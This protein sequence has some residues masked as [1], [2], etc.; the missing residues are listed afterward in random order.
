MKKCM[1]VTLVMAFLFAMGSSCCM[2]QG[3]T[4]TSK[5]GSLLIFPK[6]DTRAGTTTIVSLLNAGSRSIDVKC[7]WEYKSSAE[8]T[9]AGNISDCYYS[10]MQFRLT[11]NHPLVFDAATGLSGNEDYQ[12]PGSNKTPQVAGFGEGNLGM[13]KC[14]AVDASAQNQVNWNYLKGEATILEEATDLGLFS[15]WEYNA[16]RF[17][18]VMPAGALDKD[19]V[20]TGGELR[21]TGSANGTGAYDAC[22]TYIGFEFLAEVPAGNTNDITLI[23]CKQNVK[24]EGSFTTTKATFTVWNENEVKFTGTHK[25]FRCF[26]EDSLYIIGIPQDNVR[27]RTFTAAVLQTDIGRARVKGLAS[28]KYCP[29]LNSVN[30]PLLGVIAS[31]FDT[32]PDWFGTNPTTAGKAT[33]DPGYIF[34]DAGEDTPEKPAL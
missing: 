7:Y 10:D 4:D 34:W 22:P 30:S 26:M 27:F 19:P 28:A 33:A 9:P 16:W 23:P 2:A 12:I 1:L 17:A 6:I 20:G 25:C 21:L 32:N 8:Q 29:G 3:V 31:Q 5:F 14:W 24:Q 18:A 11:K 15:A 13:L